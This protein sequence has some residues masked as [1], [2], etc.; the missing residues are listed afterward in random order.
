MYG[1]TSM[2]LNK[3]FPR[4]SAAWA[5]LHLEISREIC[6]TSADILLLLPVFM[7]LT[8]KNMRLI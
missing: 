1:R 3:L 6:T 5:S 8:G 2:S 7:D 4:Q